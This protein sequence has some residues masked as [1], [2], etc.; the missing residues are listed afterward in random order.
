MSVIEDSDF[1]A[2][3]EERAVL[4]RSYVHLTLSATP[5]SRFTCT[6][7]LGDRLLLESFVRTRIRELDIGMWTSALEMWAVSYVHGHPYA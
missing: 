6:N 1:D 5:Q 3:V 2:A 4:L 7:D